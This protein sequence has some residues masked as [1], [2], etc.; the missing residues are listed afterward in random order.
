MDWDA[1]TDGV[2][3][4]VTNVFGSTVLYT[5]S[6]GSS[7]TIQGVY[8]DQY[9][10]VDGQSGY[11]IATEQPHISVRNLDLNFRPRQGDLIQVKSRDFI[12]KSVQKDGEAGTIIFLHELESRFIVT[13]ESIFIT[14]ESGARIIL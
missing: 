14:T 2:F 8:R 10:E 13:E 9:L 11:T 12:A 1:L 3:R 5:P 4:T 6:G 7:I